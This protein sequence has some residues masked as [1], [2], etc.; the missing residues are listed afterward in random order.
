M[1]KVSLTAAAIQ[2]ILGAL[3]LLGWVNLTDDQLAGIMLAV[4]AMLAAL[5][6]FLSP[7]IPWYGRSQ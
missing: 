4:N 1:T 6:G 2:A 7:S 3:V 5:V